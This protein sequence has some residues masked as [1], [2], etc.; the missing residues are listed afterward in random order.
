MGLLFFTADAAI[1]VVEGLSAH[2]TGHGMSQ[3]QFQCGFVAVLMDLPADGFAVVKPD[4]S[5]C[6]LIDLDIEDEKAVI[7]PKHSKAIE[8]HNNKDHEFLGMLPSGAMV[9]YP[10]GC[11][12]ALQSSVLRLQCKEGKIEADEVVVDGNVC[13]LPR[14]SP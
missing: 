13:R 9:F 4:R 2:F 3:V 10:D 5:R 12:E 8:D 11:Y 7:T 14:G 1:S 6:H